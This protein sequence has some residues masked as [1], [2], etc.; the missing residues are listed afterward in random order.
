MKARN[1]SAISAKVGLSGKVGI[2]D[3]VDGQ[4]IGMHH[5]ALRID[6]D[7][8]DAAGRETVD[9]LD[10]ADLDDAV[11]AGIEA[12]GFRVEDDLAHRITPQ[13]EMHIR[14]GAGKSRPA[15]RR[16]FP[17]SSAMMACDRVARR[18]EAVA[19]V[20]DEIGAL[21]LFGVRHLP[22]QDRLELF[23]RHAR[24][25]QHALALDV[26]GAVTTTTLSTR[27]R[28]AGLEQQRDVEHDKRRAGGAVA[29]QER[30]G[31]GAHQRMDDR[32]QPLQRL[33]RCRARAWPA[34]CGRPTPSLTVPGKAASTS[35]A[36]APA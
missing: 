12:G 24:P 15:V 26:G 19:G 7:V 14:S 2:A 30:V 28:A 22:R 25:R 16:L 10:A 4:R 3:A 33:R 21:A 6:V 20:D 11:L 35:G 27:S 29:R 9:Q 8:E 1:S 23:R 34:R 31:I 17:V 18:I 5:A 36:A 32:F 13:R